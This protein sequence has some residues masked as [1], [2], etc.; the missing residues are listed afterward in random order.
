[1]SEVV[2]IGLLKGVKKAACGMKSV[3]LTSDPLKIFD[4][5]ISYNKA[6]QNEMNF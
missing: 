5:Y 1:M 2:G 4:I 6:L 3:D